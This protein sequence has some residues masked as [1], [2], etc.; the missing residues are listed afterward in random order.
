MLS[1]VVVAS[2]FL[3]LVASSGLAQDSRAL[4]GKFGSLDEM[5]DF[6]SFSSYNEAP[7]L[8]NLVAQGQLPPVAER[9]PAEPF[10][11]RDA[12]MLDGNGTYGDLVRRTDGTASTGYHLNAGNIAGWTVHHAY[13]ETL[14]RFGW[15]WMLG[16]PEP[17]PNLARS[18]EWSE[19]GTSLT[20]H[21]IEG[22]R[23]S[24]GQPFTADDVLY[25]YYD[26]W[27]DP[28]VP[29]PVGEGQWTFGGEVTRLEK[30]DDYTIRWTFGEPFPV[31]V[32]FQLGERSF[33]TITPAHVYK[34]F[35]P[36]Y[37]PESSYEEYVLATPMDAVPQVALGPWVPVTY[38]PGQQLIAVR[39]P[40]YWKVDEAGNQLPY[41]DVIVWT[42]AQD[43]DQWAL[44]LMTGSADIA[45]VKVALQPQ[46]LAAERSADSQFVSSWGQFLSGFH[47]YFNLSLTNSV[48]TDRDL[49]LRQLFRDL[50]FRQA[51]SHAIDREGIAGGVF[52]DPSSDP[53]F[54]G[55]TPGSPFYE[56]S[57][58][59][60]FAYDPDGSRTLLADLGFSDT[61]GDGIL[62]WSA[63]SLIPGEELIIGLQTSST[64]PDFVSTSEA[65]VPMFRE[66][67]IDLRLNPLT[68]GIAQSNINTG[69][70]EAVLTRD[71][72]LGK[73]WISPASLGSIGDN[74][75]VW[76]REGPGGRELMPFE[77]EIGELLKATRTMDSAEDRARTFA[78]VQEIF[79]EN[80]YTVGIWVERMMTGHA[81]RFQN[82]PSDY[83]VR[84]YNGVTMSVPKEIIWTPLPAQF[85]TSEF[86]G[87]IPTAEIYQSAD[88]YQPVLQGL[89]QE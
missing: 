13:R 70:F 28:Q 17:T 72:N 77:V 22:V 14:V 75:P 82:Y 54:G 27:L 42:F 80:V 74:T 44:D 35:H 8:A 33:N 71:Q 73:P 60:T 19:D 34:N 2:L 18:W 68:G 40:Y 59:T 62:N 89:G 55:I 61:D 79:T 50:T 87:L 9:L 5:I 25:T 86:E 15:M 26:E 1:G 52:P 20:M 46:A 84:I 51:I 65:L 7:S 38:V 64:D 47:L 53:Y 78:Q 69:N 56:A 23:W 37:N 16:N 57:V 43:W 48:E 29:S 24:D 12:M 10:V 45:N 3:V 66:I 63:D 67:G 83:P 4:W 39:N 11:W 41:W 88:W 58:T 85:D 31:Q 81:D 6:R 21:L 32:F 76:H 49:A 30:I 36:K